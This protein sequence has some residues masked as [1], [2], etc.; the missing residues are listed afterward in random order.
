MRQRNR[1]R[2]R[3]CS[4]SGASH[5]A[6][7]MAIL[8][9]TSAAAQG[10]SRPLRG[11]LTARRALSHSL[12]QTWPYRAL[13]ALSAVAGRTHGFDQIAGHRPFG[14]DW[15]SRLTRERSLVPTSPRS[16]PQRASQARSRPQPG[17]IANLGHGG[18][19]ADASGGLAPPGR[20]SRQVRATAAGCRVAPSA[21]GA[22]AT[23]WLRRA[24]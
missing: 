6:D 4:K 13:R 20:V 19:P 14:E 16:E 8:E 15:R 10:P 11:L 2:P 7:V 24:A 9:G 22:C 23:A 18:A 1:R 3:G 12:S 5:T 21:P 17:S